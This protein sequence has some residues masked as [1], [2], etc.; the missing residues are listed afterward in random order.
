MVGY[1]FISRY[2][3]V[4]MAF[5]HFFIE[6]FLP[7]IRSKRM[8]RLISGIINNNSVITILIVVGSSHFSLNRRHIKLKSIT[9]KRIGINPNNHVSFSAF[10]KVI[11][12]NDEKQKAKKLNVNIVFENISFVINP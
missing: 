11:I 4:V 3:F 10:S 1:S 9:I 5:P 6:A 7:V 12:I 2:S 8:K